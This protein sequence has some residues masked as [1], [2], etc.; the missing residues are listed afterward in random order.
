M[1]KLNPLIRNA[2]YNTLFAL[3]NME[4]QDDC[5]RT[6]GFLQRSIPAYWEEPELNSDMKKACQEM[7]NTK[8]E[9]HDTFLGEQ[10]KLNNIKYI[11]P[12]ALLQLPM[13]HE[14]NGIKEDKQD[15]HKARIIRALKKQ[16]YEYDYTLDGYK[17]SLK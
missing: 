16:G 11:P 9:F 8:I 2:V 14:Y 7:L 12:L 10:Y 4:K 13:L 6:A 17:K 1:E 15:K 3:A 5:L